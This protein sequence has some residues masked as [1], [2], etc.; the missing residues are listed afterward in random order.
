MKVELDTRHDA[1]YFAFVDAD[2][3]RQEKLDGTA[4]RLEGA[5]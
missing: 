2:P 3:V 1:A 5:G 4:A